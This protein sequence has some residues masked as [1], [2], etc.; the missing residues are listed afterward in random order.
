MFTIRA[1]E[2]Y[3]GRLPADLTDG[4]FAR[5]GEE[6]GETSAAEAPASGGHAVGILETPR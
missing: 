6:A 2:V 5:I 3:V 4:E 1:S